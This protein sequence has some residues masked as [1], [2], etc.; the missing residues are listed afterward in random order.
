MNCDYYDDLY[1]AKELSLDYLWDNRSYV[2]GSMFGGHKKALPQLCERVEDIL[3][4]KMIAEGNV[5]NEQIALGYLI[6]KY[7]DDFTIYERKNGKHLDIFTELG[8]Q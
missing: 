6:K 3:L 4:N 5:N 7:S 1:G 2:L 8:K